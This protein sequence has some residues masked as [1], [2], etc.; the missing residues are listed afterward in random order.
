MTTRSKEPLT[1]EIFDLVDLVRDA[2]TPPGDPEP[3][4]IAE[5]G[6][7]KNL[8]TKHN[9]ARA[10][11]SAGQYAAHLLRLAARDA[12]PTIWSTA[13]TGTT[14]AINSWD[15]DTRMYA[16]LELRK[17]Y[18]RLPRPLP[19]EAIPTSLVATWLTQASGPPLIPATA[20][21]VGYILDNIED[22]RALLPAAFYATHG[23]RLLAELTATAP[24]GG[25]GRP[26]AERSTYLELVKIAVRGIDAAA[27]MSQHELAPAAGIDRQ[28]LRTY[29]A[30]EETR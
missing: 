19:D 16:A 15:W 24:P 14:P 8:K 18:I 11:A 12:T 1:T 30:A 13:L 25:R 2:A 7:E 27:L 3:W 28:T 9:G 6:Q 10:T 20:R 21:M 23:R 4:Q 5:D 26:T 17:T 29:L 22:Y